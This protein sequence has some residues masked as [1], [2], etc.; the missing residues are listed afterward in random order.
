MNIYEIHFTELCTSKVKIKADT[1]EKAKEI[2]NSG[3]FTGD[4]IIDRDHFEIEQAYPIEEEKND[5]KR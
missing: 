2:V 1:L 4:E 5:T 3:D